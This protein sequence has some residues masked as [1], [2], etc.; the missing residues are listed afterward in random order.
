MGRR[1]LLVGWVIAM[2]GAG[3]LDPKSGS[4]TGTF[5]ADTPDSVP[6]LSVDDAGEAGDSDTANGNLCLELGCYSNDPCL[7]NDCDPKTGCFFEPKGDGEPCGDCLV[8]MGG[9]CQPE[10]PSPN[11]VLECQ[12]DTECND[13]NPCTTSTC[14]CPTSLNGCVEY[15]NCS[16]KHEPIAGCVL[17]DP[18]VWIPVTV[19]A[20]PG[21]RYGHFAAYDSKRHRMLVG[22]GT[23]PYETGGGCCKDPY[24]EYLDL[25]ALDLKTWQWSLVQE[26]TPFGHL[27]GADAAYDSEADRLWVAGDNTLYHLDLATLG[28]DTAGTIPG[29]I[30]GYAEFVSVSATEVRVLS[31][32]G[33]N[34][35]GVLSEHRLRLATGAWTTFEVP[36]PEGVR[37]HFD[38]SGSY[39]SGGYTGECAAGSV[40][41]LS[42][43]GWDVVATPPIA[44]RLNHQSA[45]TASDH[46]VL[47][48][49]G[50][51]CYCGGPSC[52]DN[53][54]AVI[55]LA[56]SALVALDTLGPSPEPV[57]DGTLI[58]AAGSNEL[59]LFGGAID[60]DYTVDALWRL[61]LP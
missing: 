51:G 39:L 13:A 33:S 56:Q 19:D 12:V 41:S 46:L 47:F 9:V 35:E 48:G 38:V 54:L 7:R 11:Q 4:A 49:G 40:W 28:W 25:W 3:C 21:P 23:D 1:M 45:R 27:F 6:D 17:P 30:Y 43:G 32:P 5:A 50:T 37:W 29:P 15:E 57:R 31:T 2:S 58:F 16:C 14:A 22:H 44:P 59:I 24:D 52:A 42:D 20:G 55:D 10:G 34:G 8:C 36:H 60:S 26:A 53:G 18:W 61:T